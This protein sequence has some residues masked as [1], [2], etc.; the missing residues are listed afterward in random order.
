MDEKRRK[1][2]ISI[3]VICL[4]A[5]TNKDTTTPLAEQLEQFVNSN[6]SEQTP[7]VL[8]VYFFY[9]EECPYCHNV[10]PFIQGIIDKY[11]NVD[12]QKLEIWHNQTNHDLSTKM[13]TELGQTNMGVPLVIVGNITLVGGKEIPDQLEGII[14]NKTGRNNG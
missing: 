7:K 11:P 3:L 10:M 1:L 9:G 6:P 14:I 5:L 8:T 2:I 4:G 13:L 12:V